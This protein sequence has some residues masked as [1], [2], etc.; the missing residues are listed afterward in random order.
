MPFAPRGLCQKAAP[1]TF[2][3]RLQKKPK[4]ACILAL[5]TLL[6]CDSCIPLK[7]HSLGG[8]GTVWSSGCHYVKNG[9]HPSSLSLFASSPAAPAVRPTQTT[10][11]QCEQFQPQ[12]RGGGQ[13]PAGSPPPLWHRLWPAAS[14]PEDEHGRRPARVSRKC[15]GYN[16][17]RKLPAC[18][19]GDDCG[20]QAC[21]YM[22]G[23]HPSSLPL[24]ACS[25]QPLACAAFTH[26]PLLAALPTAGAS[27]SRGRVARSTNVVL[28]SD[29]SEEKWRELDSQVN[30]YPG[31][32]L[33]A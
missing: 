13:R 6:N 20:L 10:A 17:I 29:E 15:V 4:I 11:V 12:Q 22:H 23:R 18:R 7:D 14:I 9:I 24:P 30:E 33:T 3:Q 19:R 1:N 31:E 32:R 5:Y 8:D 2:L 26:A 25:L 21:S 28:G 16:A 27:A